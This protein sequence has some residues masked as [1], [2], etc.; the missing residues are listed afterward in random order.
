MGWCPGSKE[1]A[2]SEILGGPGE[3]LEPQE[4][5]V[6]DPSSHTFTSIRGARMELSMAE[7]TLQV[8]HGYAKLPLPALSPPPCPVPP[9]P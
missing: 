4:G 3:D 1:W 8:R 6:P 9:L 5:P 2:G 7:R